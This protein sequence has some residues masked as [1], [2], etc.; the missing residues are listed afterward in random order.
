LHKRHRELVD[1]ISSELKKMKKDG[2]IE[3]LRLL[4]LKKYEAE[5]AG[6]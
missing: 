4:A 6:K 3:E 5:H 2:V 1:N